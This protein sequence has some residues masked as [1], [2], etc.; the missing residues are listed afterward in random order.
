[1]SMNTL[2]AMMIKNIKQ[3]SCSRMKLKINM[4]ED[5][6]PLKMMTQVQWSPW[7]K[8]SMKITNQNLKG[9]SQPKNSMTF[10]LELNRILKLQ[11][12]KLLVPATSAVDSLNILNFKLYSF[13]NT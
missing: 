8:S 12:G 11:L 6:Q 4:E 10:E 5:G 2:T 1:M 3:E 13:Q 9:S 7:K